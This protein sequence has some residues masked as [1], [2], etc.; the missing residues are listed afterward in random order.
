MGYMIRQ[1][2]GG[3]VSQN[4]SRKEEKSMN[5]SPSSSG[6]VPKVIRLIARVISILIIA[7][8]GFFIV[9]ELIGNKPSD[10]MPLTKDDYIQFVMMAIWFVGLVVAWKKEL[11]GG[12][13]ILVAFAIHTYI[14]FNVLISIAFLVPLAGLLFL[15][16]WWLRR[17]KASVE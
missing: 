11:V 7:I 4:T 8:W 9:A 17:P 1:K 10:G 5:N 15:I 13:M 12:I 16:S 2:D 14:N 3:Q 6:F